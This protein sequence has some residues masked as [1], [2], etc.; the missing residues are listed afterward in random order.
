M[1]RN[2]WTV[3][4][5]ENGQPSDVLA[6]D[7]KT[8]A[9][10]FV[11]GQGGGAEYRII[12]SYLNVRKEKEESIPSLDLT[13][14]NT[15]CIECLLMDNMHLPE[16]RRK[17]ASEFAKQHKEELLHEAENIVKTYIEKRFSDYVGERIILG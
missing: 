13:D 12:K 5:T 7:E 8:D 15:E 11:T 4:K 17:V 6:F 10:N 2:I 1:N 14:F 9:E 3:V 16:E